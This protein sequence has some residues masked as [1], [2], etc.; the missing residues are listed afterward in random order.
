[1]SKRY[2]DVDRELFCKSLEA[3]GFIPDPE[4]FGELVYMRQH[5]MDLTMYVK[6]Y[7]S[8]SIRGGDTRKCGKD[9]IRVMLIFSNP[10]TGRSGCLYKTPRVYRTGSQEAVIERT[11]ERAREAYGAGVKRVRGEK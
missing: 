11:I 4:A 7:T 5:H 6:I 8:M 1:M 3:K 9:A 2:V 10:V